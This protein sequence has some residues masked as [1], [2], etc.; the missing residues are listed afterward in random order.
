LEGVASDVLTKGGNVALLHRSAVEQSRLQAVVRWSDPDGAEVD[1]A[2]LLLGPDGRVRSD[3]DF[4]FYNAPSGGDGAVRLLGKRTGNDSA[5]DRVAVDLEALPP[6]VGTVVILASLDAADGVGFGDVD[7]L[8]LDVVDAGGESRVRFDVADAGPET[9]MVL[10]ELYLRG[11][12][13]KFRAVGQGW[14]SGLAGLATDYGIDVA[15]PT[16]D[17]HAPDAPPADHHDEAETR[18]A[19]TA[20]ADADARPPER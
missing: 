17:L 19:A 5:E 14:D 4:V 7:G 2:A 18:P 20:V 16:T 8:A 11:E 15:D 10:G 9:A 13:W 3:E 6:D 1:V 12:E